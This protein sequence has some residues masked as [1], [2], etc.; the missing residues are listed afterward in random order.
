MKW[1]KNMK[2]S[3]RI[4]HFYE[5]ENFQTGNCK[6]LDFNI[7]QWH[8]DYKRRNI[9]KNQFDVRD[10]EEISNF[11][12]MEIEKSENVLEISQKNTI[13]EVLCKF[14]VRM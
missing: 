11:L 5:V 9:L 12:G 13:E 4:Y 6:N 1:M 8:T 7:R 10:I 3:H 2:Q 14:N